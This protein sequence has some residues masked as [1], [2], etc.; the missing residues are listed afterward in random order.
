M[1]NHKQCEEL[2]IILLTSGFSVYNFFA[3][4][5]IFSDTNADD[6]AENEAE[7]ND[8]INSLTLL[9]GSERLKKHI[10]STFKGKVIFAED[11]NDD[12]LLEELTIVYG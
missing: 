7:N 10:P 2:D 12:T 9:L 3:L 11:P 1:K 8:W 6:Y 5:G 4:A